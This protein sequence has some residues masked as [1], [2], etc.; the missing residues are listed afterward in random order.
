MTKKIKKSES[1]FLIN[2]QCG[3][4]EEQAIARTM[5]N[6]TLQSAWTVREY[7]NSPEEL[8]LQA[9]IDCMDK[10]VDVYK[11]GNLERIDQMLLSQA[12][13]LDAIAN[14]LFRRATVQEYQRNLES[15]MKLGLKAQSQ[16]R[17]TLETLAAIKSPQSVAFV[18][19]QNVGYNQQVNNKEP[20]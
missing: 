8:D 1:A 20:L 6:P 14:N 18:R 3:E 15:F 9:L 10:Q 13:T 17:A 11:A 16:C 4:S 12:H 7:V 2:G 5:L 19:Q